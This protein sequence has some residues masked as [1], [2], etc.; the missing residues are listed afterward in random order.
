M[1]AFPC[2]AQKVHQECPGGTIPVL[3]MLRNG[4]KTKNGKIASGIHGLGSQLFQHF[5]R[6]DQT[7]L[8]GFRQVGKDYPPFFQ[9]SRLKQQTCIF[10]K[11]ELG[12]E[13]RNCPRCI[14][15][16]NLLLNPL[17]E[18]KMRDKGLTQ[19]QVDRQALCFILWG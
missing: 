8:N 10:S 5:Q 3:L 16:L 13:V 1:Q 14:S 17:M 12:P 6:I 19:A 15:V 9:K 18:L 2:L 11:D 4:G 7:L